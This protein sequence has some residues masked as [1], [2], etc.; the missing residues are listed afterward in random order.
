MDYLETGI[1]RLLREALAAHNA[2]A[3]CDRTSR[4]NYPAY[5]QARAANR[6]RVRQLVRDLRWARNSR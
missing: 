2:F 1:I 3:Y 6:R 5:R 4:P